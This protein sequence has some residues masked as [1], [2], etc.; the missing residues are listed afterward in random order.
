MPGVQGLPAR[1]LLQRA[2]FMEV[3]PRRRRA[4]TWSVQTAS[5]GLS[6]RD[7]AGDRAESA[8]A[9]HRCQLQHTRNCH[10]FS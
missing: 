7:T 9:G 5:D 2:I 1:L 4:G 8:E 3:A 6:W 10:K